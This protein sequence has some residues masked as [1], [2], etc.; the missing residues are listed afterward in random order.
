[1]E[2][3]RVGQRTSESDRPLELAEEFGREQWRSIGV[4]HMRY[5]WPC[6]NRLSPLHKLL[7][8]I[9]FLLCFPFD[10]KMRLSPAKSNIPSRKVLGVC[11]DEGA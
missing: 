11:S 1:M 4:S 5:H 3:N 2:N 9:L 8:T 7:E 10:D 6:T